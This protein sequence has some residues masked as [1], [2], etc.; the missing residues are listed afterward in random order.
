MPS[1]DPAICVVLHDVAPET[2]SRCE[3]LLA[4][5]D[6]LG[7]IPLT[8]LVVPEYHSRRSIEREPAFV[9]AI[10]RRILR[11]DETVLHGLFHLD[12]GKVSTGSPVAWVK[13]RCYTRGEGEFSTLS[14]AQ[15]WERLQQG[16]GC[17][18]RLGWPVDGFV[19]PAWLMSRGTRSAIS[20]T[21]LRYTS[22]RRR[23]YRLPDWQPFTSPS[24]V[25]SVSTH[26]RRR[27]S[28]HYN[29]WLRQRL[30]HAPL[31]RLGLHPV[32]AE[33]PELVAFWLETLQRALATHIP[34][35]KAAWLGSAS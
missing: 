33:H 12:D 35:T 16:L 1:A 25:W 27:L 4:A 32:D 17:F 14:E 6:A 20:R 28:A 24:L 2:W 31:L 30:Q 23:L 3:R 21:T 34:M 15:A 22:T 7:A 26:W 9:R 13:R 8:L 19:A 18:R 5:I 10:E 29:H 11:G